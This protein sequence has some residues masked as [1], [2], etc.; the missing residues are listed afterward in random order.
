MQYIM[1]NMKKIIV[2]I[3]AL[4]AVILIVMMF[5]SSNYNNS[6]KEDNINV[7]TNINMLDTENK[8]VVLKTSAG[9]IKMELLTSEAPKTVENFIKLAGEGFYDQTRFHRVIKDFMIQG[10][11]PLSKEDANRPFWGTGGPGYQFEDEENNVTLVQGVVAMANSGPDTN[12]SQFFIIT[13]EATPWLQGK[14]T[15][16]GRVIEGMDIVMEIG[17]TEVGSGDQPVVDVVVNGVEVE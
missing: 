2:G 3:I 13:A 17:N 11:D 1:G 9:D 14:H 4:V 7:N 5:N 12:G 15:G 8:I 6:I 16:F 10:G